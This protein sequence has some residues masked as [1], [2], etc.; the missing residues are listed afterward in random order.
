M[1]HFLIFTVVI[2]FFTS[3]SMPEKFRETADFTENWQFLLADSIENYAVNIPDNA[4]WR[5][6]N[7]PHDWSIEAD[8]S[9]T[10]PATPGG[11]ALPGG[12][13]WY[14]KVFEIDRKWKDKKIFIDFDGIYCNSEVWMN[15]ASIG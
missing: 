7:L 12:V 9:E 14:R 3:C 5:T 8:F 11:G 2:S 15:G 4:A 1:K 10:N 6:L 13:G